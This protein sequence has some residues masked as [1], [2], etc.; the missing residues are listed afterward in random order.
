MSNALRHVPNVLTALRLATAPATAGLLIG[1]YFQAAFGVFAFAGISDA[2]DG[3]LAKRFGLTTRFGRILDPAA[4]KALMLAVFVTLAYLG[5]IPSWLT[6]LV[7]GRDIFIVVGIGLLLLSQ[8]PFVIAPLFIGKLSTALQIVYIGAH[9]AVLAFGWSLGQLLPWDA[10]VIAFV[11]VLS[12][13]AYGLV[14][15]RAFRAPVRQV[16]AEA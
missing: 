5:Q 16:N 10:Y 12:A 1:G 3:F 2:G 15:F 8:A 9:L 14:G 13:L 11:T 4:D 7:I 6:G